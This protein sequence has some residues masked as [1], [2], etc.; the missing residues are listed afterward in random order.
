MKSIQSALIWAANGALILLW[1]PVLAVVRLFDRDPAHYATGRAFRFLGNLFTR[2][3]PLWRVHIE[4]DVPEDPRRPYVVVSNHQSNADIPVI[5]RLPWEMKWVAKAE[6][7]K[8]PVV[9]WLLRMAGDIAVDRR[10]PTSRA[11]VLVAAR[12]Y[13]RERCSVMF[14]PEGTRSR[15]GRVRSFAP[16]AFR[17]AIEAGV[18]VL[19]LAVD[20]TR[21]ALPKHGWRF[22]NAIDARVRVLPPVPTDGLGA[23][24]VDALRDRVRAGIIAQVAAWRGTSPEAVD[25]LSPSVDA[26]TDASADG[27]EETAKLD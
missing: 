4:G 1:L 22:G 5:S 8:V 20:G 17:L 3:N 9:G 16:G 2:T 12:D 15:D 19:P 25:A 18:P 23:G 13:L 14:F 27:V 11:H 10:D 6:L 24:D 7:F 26:A 21:D